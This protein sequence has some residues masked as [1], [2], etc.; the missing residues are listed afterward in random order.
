MPHT[1]TVSAW[2]VLSGVQPNAKYLSNVGHICH[3]GRSS[4]GTELPRD[5]CPVP[6]LLQKH[7][8]Q[9]VSP[10]PLFHGK[11]LKAEKCW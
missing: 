3:R 5:S 10:C 11:N 1:E 2:D 4:G 6:L 7:Y 9:K 8:A